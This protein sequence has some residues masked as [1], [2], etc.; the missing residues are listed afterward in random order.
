[1][2]AKRVPQI[3]RE[4]PRGSFVFVILML[5]VFAAA[6]TM[7]SP[8]HVGY[9][10]VATLSQSVDSPPLLSIVATAECPPALAY[11]SVLSISAFYAIN[12]HGELP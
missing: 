10:D 9:D 4:K 2:R 11:Q 12:P 1:M 5:F 6:P 8:Q 3:P 7:G